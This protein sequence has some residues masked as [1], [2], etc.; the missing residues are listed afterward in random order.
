M[1]RQYLMFVSNTKVLWITFIVMNIIIFGVFTN[2]PNLDGLVID[3][4]QSYTHEKLMLI[5]A[6]M[7]EA[8]R[9]SYLFGNAV[10]MLYPFFYA[11]FFAGF[12]YR[13]RIRESLRFLSVVPIML[14]FIDWGENFQ[15]RAMLHAYP[16]ISAA[17]VETASL[18][19]S[20]KHMLT[21]TM[22]GLFTVT[23]IFVFVRW[24]RARG[25][26]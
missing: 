19:S 3:T 16:E 18:F 1:F 22:L 11:S 5:L 26:N 24:L 25:D 9:A 20:V 6:E 15:I 23:C 13:V 10:D 8:G 2:L 4:Q 21:L 7:G 14:A 12:L 17:Q